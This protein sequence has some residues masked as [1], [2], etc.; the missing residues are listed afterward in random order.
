MC[1]CQ[2]EHSSKGRNRMSNSSLFYS[3]ETGAT[4][5]ECGKSIDQCSKNPYANPMDGQK[6]AEFFY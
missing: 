1:S 2:Q 4:F 6:T 3:T 5:P